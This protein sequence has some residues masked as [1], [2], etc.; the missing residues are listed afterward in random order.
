MRRDFILLYSLLYTV[1]NSVPKKVKDRNIKLYNEFSLS[2]AS[3]HL[4]LYRDAFLFHHVSND[5]SKEV[6]L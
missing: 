1:R 4:F 6:S 3:V 2:N 5:D